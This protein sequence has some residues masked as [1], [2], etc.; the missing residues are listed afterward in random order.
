MA[1]NQQNTPAPI[2]TTVE[3]PEAWQ[4]VVKAEIDRGLYAREYAARLKKAA[5][6]HKRPG[7][8]KGKTPMAVVEKELGGALHYEVIDALIQKAWLTAVIEHQLRPLTDPEPSGGENLAPGDEGDLKIDMAVEV[9]PEITAAGLDG[10]PV[11]RREVSVADT[12]IDE[13]LERLRE[14]R[15]TWEKVERAAADGD[16][17]T[18]DLLPDAGLD[19]D[20]ER[21]PITDQR[22]VLGE[23]SNMP[24]FNET[25]AG[26]AA[27]DARDVSVVYPEDHP[28]ERLRGRTIVFA[29]TIKAV[30]AKVLPELDDAFAGAVEEGKSLDDLKA[31][32]RTDLEKE[33]ERRVAGELDEQILRELVARNEVPLPPSMVERYLD[34]GLEEMRR[35]NERM[36]RAA[37]PDDEAQYREAG[38]PHAERALKGMLLLEAV[39][40]QED[41]KV[42][43]ADVDEK[44][45]AIAAEH[46]F[47]VDDYRKFVDSGEGG[48]RDR[49][50][51]ELLERRTYDFLL[52]RAEIETVAADTDVL[53][54]EKE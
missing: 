42:E 20:G 35:R 44:I 50:E 8:R 45:A 43:A 31:V 10:I 23:E 14:S 52:S 47:P 25:L 37:T 39:R 40:R 29:C 19:G 2:R 49:I 30:E 12:D 33:A 18:L 9:R 1:E 53:D 36:G 41:I 38:R 32:I 28:N 13:V 54:T 46:G 48:E 7:F 6:S 5:R 15:S 17:L 22:F 4:R 51:Y 27:G 24:A 34:G 26:A 16:R 21:Q 11:R 3:A